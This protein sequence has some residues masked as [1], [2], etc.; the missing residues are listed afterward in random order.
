MS[1]D[2]MTEIEVGSLALVD[3]NQAVQLAR[4]EIDIQI[5][6]AHAFPRSFARTHKAMLDLVTLDKEAAEECMYS[7]PVDGAP[8]IGPSIRFAEA[9]KQAYGNCSAG[10]RVTEINRTDLYV[11]AEGVFLDLESNVRTTYRTRRSIR[12]RNGRIYADRMIVM[13]CNAACSISMREAILK[14][15]P[16]MLWRAAWNAVTQAVRGDIKTLAERRRE[17]VAG[18]AKWG[19][20]A[21]RI[22]AKLGVAG[23]EDVTLD[24]LPDL[25]AMFRSIRDGEATV[26]DYFPKNGAVV[27]PLNDAPTE[28]KATPAD[29]PSSPAATGAEAKTA[30]APEPSPAAPDAPASAPAATAEVEPLPDRV[31]STGEPSASA[32]ITP[33]PTFAKSRQRKA[34]EAEAADDQPTPTA[35]VIPDEEA[36]KAAAEAGKSAFYTGAPRRAVPDKFRDDIDLAAAFWGGFDA[37]KKEDMG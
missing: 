3:A 33:E 32:T 35:K 25:R 26:E 6:T 18:F 13:T 27:D 22:F 7:L 20:T 34:P 4:A 30:P 29:S 1:A 9:L 23:I 15:V 24:H 19:V 11:E 17:A 2:T 37:A 8:V 36:L 31:Q 5:S 10:A 21:D 16:K 14:G 12:G 28:G